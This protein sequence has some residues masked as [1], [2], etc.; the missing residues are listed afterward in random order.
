MSR[1]SIVE[2]A[3]RHWNG[4]GDLVYTEHP[5]GVVLDRASEEISPGILTFI[6]IA[7][8]NAIDSGDV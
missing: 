4:D 2:M 6:S 1:E 3:E 5:V 8:V 7:S